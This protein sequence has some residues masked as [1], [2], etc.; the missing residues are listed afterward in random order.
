MAKRRYSKYTYEDTQR[1]I[2][3]QQRSLLVTILPGSASKNGRRI[4]IYSGKH[5]QELWVIIL[6]RSSDWYRFNL[7][8]YRS[9]IEAAIVGTHDS[10]VSVPV[11]AMDTLEWY[12]PYRTR[13]EGLLSP[14]ADLRLPDRPDPFERLRRTRYGHCVLVGALIVGRTEARD[15]LMTLPDRTRF[16]LEAEVRR[17]RHRRAG[18]PLKLWEDELQPA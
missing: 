2:Q 1:A 18:R 15:R 11:L 5:K 3:Q 10:C 9:G 12:A 13:F 6:A 4:R 14:A 17:L 16:R 7:N 8:T